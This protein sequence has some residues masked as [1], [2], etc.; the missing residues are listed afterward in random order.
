MKRLAPLLVGLVILGA[1]AGSVLGVLLTRREPSQSGASP[2]PSSPAATPGSPVQPSLEPGGG[3]EDDPN[4][5]GEAAHE[6]PPAATPPRAVP[7]VTSPAPGVDPYADPRQVAFNFINAWATFDWRDQ[8]SPLAGQLARAKPWVTPD[9][10]QF[11]SEIREPPY[12]TSEQI[13]TQTT[14]TV[15]EID[16]CSPV[17]PS[18][19]TLQTFWCLFIEMTHSTENEPTGRGPYWELSLVKREGRWLVDRQSI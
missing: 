1:I 9:F 8:P 5:S 4:E 13:R 18:S 3:A 16:N 15:T 7:A 6:T 14:T 17:P 12:L 11:L 2:A 19:E 10:F